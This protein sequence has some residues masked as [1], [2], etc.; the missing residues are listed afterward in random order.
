MRSSELDA[1]IATTDVHS[2][3][4]AFFS[5]VP[6]LHRSRSASLVVDC[7]DFFHGPAYAVTAGD[8][9]R[10]TLTALYDVLA[11]GNHGYDHHLVEP[12]RGLTVCANVRLTS[13][14]LLFRPVHV[15][16]V[17]GRRVGVTGVIGE[18][19]FASVPN[20]QRAGHRW[21]DPAQALRRVHEEYQGQVDSWILLSHSG[22]AADL[23]LT[24]Q[25]P[26]LDVVFAGHCHSASYG[27][28]RAGRAVVVKGPERGRGFARAVW[29]GDGWDAES[30]VFPPQSGEVPDEVAPLLDDAAAVLQRLQAPLGPVDGRWLSRPLEAPV[31]AQAVAEA[32][33]AVSGAA[34]AVNESAFRPVELG[35]VLRLHD[36]VH[37][38]PYGNELLLV[39]ADPVGVRLLMERAVAATPSAAVA[40]PAGSQTGGVVV[41]DYLA[42]RLGVEG[43]PA[44]LGFTEVVGRVLRS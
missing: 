21:C 20:A 18:R 36:V 24:E 12:L 38:A 34:V 2:A 8:V 27:P 5:A 32:V 35:P 25:L 41:T 13:G 33:A 4:G 22:F 15:A 23:E 30:C 43:Q 10:R 42:T 40:A 39:D 37:L 16:V 29:T 19:A 6:H 11:V 1:V 9:E 3:L 14:D 26:F 31:V 28:E 7:G 17:A 44:G